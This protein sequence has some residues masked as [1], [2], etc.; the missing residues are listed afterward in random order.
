M[1]LAQPWETEMIERHA[2]VRAELWWHHLAGDK[3]QPVAEKVS[4]IGPAMA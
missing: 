2:A 4:K 1:L 3:V